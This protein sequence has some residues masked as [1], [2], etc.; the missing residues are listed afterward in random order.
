MIFISVLIGGL[1]LSYNRTRNGVVPPLATR[2]TRA[3]WPVEGATAPRGSDRPPLYQER[4]IFLCLREKSTINNMKYQ[5]GL[6]AF[7]MGL[8]V[9]GQSSFGL[10]S[11]LHASV[12]LLEGLQFKI[13][14]WFSRISRSKFVLTYC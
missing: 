4:G 12:T 14:L 2:L 9:K 3:A 1:F 7:I 13:P 11:P 10:R 5:T 6:A 8:A